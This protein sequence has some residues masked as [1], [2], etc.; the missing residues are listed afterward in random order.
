MCALADL[1]LFTYIV[2][3]A[4]CMAAG[5]VALGAAIAEASQ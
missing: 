3:C 4:F 5:S 2:A 1:I